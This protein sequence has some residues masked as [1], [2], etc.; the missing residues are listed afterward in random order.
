MQVNVTKNSDINKLAGDVSTILS[1][2]DIK[3]L[4]YQI[5]SGI[6]SGSANTKYEIR[7]NFKVPPTVAIPITGDVYIQ[8]ISDTVLDVRSTQTSIA[9]R[10]L[11][12]L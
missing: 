11:V 8:S 12:L 6:T 1:N 7:H 4:K 2:L 3:N 5:V 10:L 9:F